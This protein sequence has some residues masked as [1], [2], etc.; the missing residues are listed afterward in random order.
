[1]NRKKFL[2]ALLSILILLSTFVIGVSASGVADLPAVGEG[3]N[4][5]YFLAPDDWFNEHTDKIGIYWWDGTDAC[6]SWPG[7]V[8]HKA[9]ADNVYYYDVPEDV[10]MII[11]NNNIDGGSTKDDPMYEFAKQ[12]AGISCEYYEP[13]E[14]EHIPDGTSSFDGMI[15][16]ITPDWYNPNIFIGNQMP[17]GYW[18][19]YY[20]NG[21]Y[22]NEPAETPQVGYNR[23]Y[24]LMPGD[25]CNELT[26]TAGIYWWEGTNAQVSWPGVKATQEENSCSD[27]MIFYCDVPDDVT[28]IIW[29]NFV[30][31]STED[32]STK[33]HLDLSTVT[34][35]LENPDDYD[36]KIY[37]INPTLTEEKPDG[38]K[39]YTG[40]W[41]EYQAGGIHSQ[42]I[43]GDANGN[44]L[45][46]VK[47]ATA[48][49]KYVAET[50]SLSE[51]SLALADFND[52]GAVDI[53]D[54]TAIQKNL[55]F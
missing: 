39:V 54:A 4:R 45:L 36:G 2:A 15:Y 55:V 19:Y 8:A 6:E 49:Q 3:Y 22:G 47:D 17:W 32:F 31:L 7:Y 18:Y 52:D 23:Y 5:Y 37:I 24:F 34:I 13:G 20:G 1:M 27:E 26:D 40:E 11:W 41:C 28:Q 44:G 42:G 25:W 16:V 46:N 14:V 38:R 51:R 21:E 12:T 33:R 10:L 30:A 29:N 53:K 9:D 43:K 50:I 48:I 35:T